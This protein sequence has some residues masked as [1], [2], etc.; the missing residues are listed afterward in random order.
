MK[1]IIRMDMTYYFD[2]Y[3]VTDMEGYLKCFLDAMFTSSRNRYVKDMLE[4][5]VKDPYTHTL[6]LT[7]VRNELKR[8]MKTS[9]LGNLQDTISVYNDVIILEETI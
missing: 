6:I 2:G 9:D 3:P 1:H 8:L 4:E 5:C 7:L